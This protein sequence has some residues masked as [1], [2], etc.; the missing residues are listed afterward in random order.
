MPKHDVDR[1]LTYLQRSRSAPID[2]GVL[3]LH[4]P[5]DL[6]VFKY[7][8]PHI[9]RT[10]SLIVHGHHAE[11]R[12]A[13]LLFCTPSPTL[14]LLE[15][16]STRGS[17]R[18]PDDFL[19]QQ[20]PSLSSVSFTGVYPAF[21]ST[22]PLP[23]LIEFKLSLPESADPFHVGAL[24]HFFSGCPWLQKI[25]INSKETP[26]DV[27]LDQVIS[28]ESLVELDYAC[29]LVGRIIPYLRLPRL[30]RL[31]VSSSFGSGQAQKL[32]DFLPH[33]GHVLL[34]EATK[35]LYYSDEQSQ[36]VR[37]YG[38]ETLLSYTAFRT[39]ADRSPIDWF[40][41][42]TCIP[43]GRIEKLIVGGSVTVDSPINILD[44]KNLRIF[45]MIQWNT[46]FAEG[47]LRSL[48]PHP[49]GE[50][51]CQSLR[52]IQYTYRGSLR[53]LV[54]LVKERKRAGHQLRLVSLSIIHGSEEDLVE[55]LKEHV[56]EVLITT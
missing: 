51:P 33:G 30:K 8:I 11:V 22:L 46:S 21:W 32:A 37:F 53:P 12:A 54:N 34:A 19:G 49:G 27:T 13:S 15:I 20:A 42:E 52:E 56:Y 16:N 18:L 40:F 24:F 43:F 1:T 3:S 4:S 14:Q 45:Q 36:E 7:L 26:Q 25:Y 2:I 28:L 35:M 6:E 10:R 23:S 50:I 47:L 48:H 39:T 5:Q 29:N 38:D 17:V 44:F 55:E 31:H 41:D 9:T